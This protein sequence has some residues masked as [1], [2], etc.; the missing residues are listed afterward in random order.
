MARSGRGKP[1]PPSGP[2]RRPM[3]VERVRELSAA[4]QIAPPV[5]PPTA[6]AEGYIRL[7]RPL[8][9]GVPAIALPEG[10]T[11]DTLSAD[12]AAAVHALLR[13]AYATGLGAV[14]DR[15]LEWWN[16]VVRDGEYDRSLAFVARSAGDVVGFC[17]CWTSSFIKDL[18]VAPLWRNRGIGSALLSTAIT[19][20]QARGAEDVALKVK[21][22]NGA[23]QRLY[24]QFGFAQ[25]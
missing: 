24:R 14:P 17:L 7:R 21:I 22:Y 15:S 4:Q 19:A 6:S 23:A 1:G 13:A 2:Q 25:D 3:F 8:S 9:L 11:I 10:V 16:G 18:V 20:L 12:D 5:K